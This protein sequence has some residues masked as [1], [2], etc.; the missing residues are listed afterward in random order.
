MKKQNSSFKK[1]NFFNVSS[2]T[3]SRTTMLSYNLSQNE[4]EC[5]PFFKYFTRPLFPCRVGLSKKKKKNSRVQPRY[6]VTGS[7]SFVCVVGC[8]FI[9]TVSV[10]QTSKTQAEI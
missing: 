10:Y 7:P 4:N 5:L 3:N 9:M 1:H 8:A 6:A 2:I